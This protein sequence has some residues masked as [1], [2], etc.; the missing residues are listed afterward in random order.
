[1]SIV[2]GTCD[3]NGIKRVFSEL[4]S[5]F[6]FGIDTTGISRI[7]QTKWTSMLS[8]VVFGS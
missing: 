2:T 6:V 3:S 5:V 4:G 1:M 8:V 7:T